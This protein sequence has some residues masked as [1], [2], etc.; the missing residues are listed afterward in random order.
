MYALKINMEIENKD[1]NEGEP[2]DPPL[3]SQN[4]QAANNVE[5]DSRSEDMVMHTDTENGVVVPQEEPT[6]S[7]SMRPISWVI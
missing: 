4:G 5:G 6:G 1:Q 7:L 2:A 3:P